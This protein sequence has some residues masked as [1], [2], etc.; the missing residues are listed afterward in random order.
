MCFAIDSTV[1]NLSFEG[2]GGWDGAVCFCLDAFN[3]CRRAC[4]YFSCVLLKRGG[5]GS[6][7]PTCE[8][9]DSRDRVCTRGQ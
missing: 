9:C 7:W 6:F 1:F 2:Q 5:G 4:F 8:V 3:K